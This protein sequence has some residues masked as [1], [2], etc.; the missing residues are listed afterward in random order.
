M[1]SIIIP[2]RN[3]VYLEK[4]I[5]SVLDNAWGEVEV[6]VVLDGYIPDPQIITNDNRVRF[7]H[8]EK[9]IG[10]RQCINQAARLAKGAYIMKLDAHCALDKG[11]D[12]KL[13]KDCQ[14]NWTVIPRMYNLDIKTWLPKWHKLTDYMY[15]GI[16][17]KNELRSL[18]YTGDEY[19]RKH[20]NKKKIDITMGCM[21]PCFFMRKDRFW[22]LGG[23]DES[24]GGWGS[25]GIEVA[26]KAWL[27]GG[28]LVVNKNTWFAHWFRGNIGFPYD[29]SGGDVNR[30]RKYSEDLWLNNK[31]EKQVRP[32]QWLVAKF[33]PPNWGDYWKKP[34]YFKGKKT[35]IK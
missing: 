29:I 21:A 27:S 13:A 33:T 7:I 24:H 11:F 19:F 25:Q 22:E 15:I 12:V 2:A 6:L 1:V 9:S 5:H 28:K 8:N 14:Y 30:A 31:W 34:F 3:E 17:E 23:C 35:R 26:C 20:K 32:F 4:T 10:Q 16:N 18:Y